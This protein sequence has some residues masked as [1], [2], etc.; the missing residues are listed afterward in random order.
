MTWTDATFASLVDFYP[1]PESRLATVSF[2]ANLADAPSQREATD[3]AQA[4]RRDGIDAVFIGVDLNEANAYAVS[5]LTTTGGGAGSVI[6]PDVTGSLFTLD[7]PA[8]AWAD[9]M[10][11]RWADALKYRELART[12]RADFDARLS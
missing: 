10:V 5:C 8:R 2:G 4:H 11:D 6:P 12:S 7:D 3:L 1:V 9:W